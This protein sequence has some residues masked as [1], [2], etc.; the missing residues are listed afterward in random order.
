[1]PLR[2]SICGES[3]MSYLSRHP[4]MASG[5][6]TVS[7]ALRVFA[8]KRIPLKWKRFASG[9]GGLLP[10]PLWGRAGRGLVVVSRTASANCYPHPQPLPSRLRACPLPATI[11]LTNPGEPGLVG[12]E[13]SRTEYAATVL[14]RSSAECHEEDLMEPQP[15]P[16]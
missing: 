15:D 4:A 2:V 16:A 11:K 3:G 7:F 9:N 8:K 13:G 1:M 5:L 12:G 10:P 6:G 14:R